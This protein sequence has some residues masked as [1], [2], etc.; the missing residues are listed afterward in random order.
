MARIILASASTVR[1]KLLTDAGLDF[2]ALSSDVDEDAIKERYRSE[3]RSVEDTALALAQAKALAVARDRP[4][5]LV[6]GADQIL[7]LNGRMFDKPRDAAEARTHLENFS[8]E[9]HRLVTAAV[10]YRNDAELWQN[11]TAPLM[12]VR[13]LSDEFIDGYLAQIGEKAFQSVGAYQLEG[14][15]V[16]LFEAIDGD[17]FT[18]LGLPLLPLLAF[19]REHGHIAA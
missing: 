19:L 1:R 18:I 6:V 17:F 7:D 5:T 9:T 10:I 14:P 12:S 4:D 15:G 2:E 3:G 8:G 16:Q 11:V 13:R